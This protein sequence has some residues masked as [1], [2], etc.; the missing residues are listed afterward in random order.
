MS[1]PVVIVALLSCMQIASALTRCNYQVDLIEPYLGA[2]E[3]LYCFDDDGIDH[4]VDESSRLC[5]EDFSSRTDG[6]DVR[7]GAEFTLVGYS[8]YPCDTETGVLATILV[9]DATLTQHSACVANVNIT[10]DVCTGVDVASEVSKLKV[11]QEF[12]DVANIDLVLE[13]DTEFVQYAFACDE[14]FGFQADVDTPVYGYCSGNV[15]GNSYNLTSSDGCYELCSPDNT[16]QEGVT[17]NLDEGSRH[18]A[19]VSAEVVCPSGFE[20]AFDAEAE[21]SYTCAGVKEGTAN[22]GVYDCGEGCPECLAQ[23][24]ANP[25]AEQISNFA[26]VENLASVSIA[27]PASSGQTV[28]AEVTC[29]EG[30]SLAF[31][32]ET[33]YDLQCNS[34]ENSTENN[35]VWTIVNDLPVCHP[36]CGSDNVEEIENV[37]TVIIGANGI[38]GEAKTGVV[39]CAAGYA[40]AENVN[41]VFEFTCSEGTFYASAG[42][43][44][45]LKECSVPESEE[46]TFYNGDMEVMEAGNAV[47]PGRNH[48]EVRCANDTLNLVGPPTMSCTPEG[49]LVHDD[50]NPPFCAD[51]IICNAPNVQKG[52]THTGN[53]LEIGGVYT[54]SCDPSH[55]FDTQTVKDFNPGDLTA[56][57]YSETSVECA[58]EDLPE[59]IC[60]FGCLAPDFAGGAT[61]PDMAESGS[62]PYEMGAV[63]NFECLAGAGIEEG[64]AEATCEVGGIGAPVCGACSFA[65]S[66]ILS[67]ALLLTLL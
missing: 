51:T 22:A 56:N 14:G 61:Y 1:G 7:C 58:G 23:C 40:L 48:V 46:F 11:N 59:F 43:P 62:A 42:V 44:E 2:Q 12:G 41:M 28:L 67:F 30:T 17:L 20:I 26:D 49:D 6:M 45:C 18:G 53:N 4:V 25:T 13:D 5:S 63:V 35:G 64:S 34:N 47:S 8:F 66:L 15:D 36:G 50:A 65:L 29:A 37:D 27:V 38:Q 31:D 32:A 16:N 52:S 9:E 19:S 24:P 54:I 33:Q 60:Y 10:R 55:W 21:Y 57:G 39:S 3:N